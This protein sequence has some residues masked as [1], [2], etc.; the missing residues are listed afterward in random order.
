MRGKI[1]KKENKILASLL[2]A[3]CFLLP[4][5]S[6]ANPEQRH[7]PAN[8]LAVVNHA[9]ELLLSVV[10]TGFRGSWVINPESREK[11]KG[12]TQKIQKTF[13]SL[14]NIKIGSSQEVVRKTLKEP[15][16]TKNNGKIW[17]Y[18]IKNED[19]T[20]KDLLEVFFDE[21]LQSVIGVIAFDPNRIVEKIGVNIGDPIDK[22]IL[23][24]GEPLDEKD[25]IEDPD[26]KQYLGLYYLYPKS[27]IGF[28]IGQDK[29]GKEAKNINVQGVLVF[30]KS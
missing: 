3:F 15:Q 13:N 8:S 16:E 19:G 21:K 6:L 29:Q 14:A 22:M 17:I 28:L 25:F 4:V 2:L 18:G 27:G 7:N 10:D 1:I 12:V 30:G 5:S 9:R 26:N 11:T 23:A 24:Y 20:Y